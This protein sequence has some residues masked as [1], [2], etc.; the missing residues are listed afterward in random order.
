MNERTDK[1][2]ALLACSVA[3]RSLPQ[4]FS[5]DESDIKYFYELSLK[6][7]I[8]SIIAY[9]LEKNALYADGEYSLKFQ[10]DMLFSAGRVTLLEYFY[11]DVCR[12]LA[13]AGIDYIP[14]KGAVIR[15]IYPEDYFR[16]SSDIDILVRKDDFERACKTLKERLG[17][18]DGYRSSHDQ[19]L[20]RSPLE[21][22]E[23]HFS[24]IENDRANG[25]NAALADAWKNAAPKNGGEYAFSGEFFMFY[26]IAHILKH[27][28]TSGCGIRFF[29][30]LYFLRDLACDGARFARMLEGYGLTAFYNACEKLVD[31]WFCGAEA[32]ELTRNLSDF[33]VGAGIYGNMDNYVAIGK[34]KRG[35]GLKYVLSR[36]F[37]PYRKLKE[38]YPKLDGKRWLTPFYQMKRWASMIFRGDLKRTAAEVREASAAGG[39]A[40]DRIAKLFDELGIR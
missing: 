13:G 37:L 9:A 35:G 18:R 16:T 23:L 29:I 7:D 25:V 26:H 28:E 24:L 14:L 2:F 15:K 32:D 36:A 19:A 31:H 20:M 27:F 6:H 40:A 34:K 17:L 38:Y 4:G 22:V 21:T 5:C 11:A 12:E 10:D 8:T 1:F 30:D 33:I 39:D 3:G